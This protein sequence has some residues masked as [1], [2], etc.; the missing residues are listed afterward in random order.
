[1]LDLRSYESQLDDPA[2]RRLHISGPVDELKAV[3]NVARLIFIA[4]LEDCQ[5]GV[6]TEGTCAYSTVLVKMMLESRT[7]YKVTQKGGDGQGD[8]G[9]FDAAGGHGHYW[10]EVDTAAGAYVVDITA[11]QFGADPVVVVP[12]SNPQYVPGDQQLVDEQFIGFIQGIVS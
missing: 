4:I 1:M 8:G 5:P 6:S 3:A 11:D 10:V 12:A 7:G 2:W 9:Y